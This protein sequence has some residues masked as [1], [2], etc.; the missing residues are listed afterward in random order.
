MTDH[1]FDALREIEHAKWLTAAVYETTYSEN[2]FSG[3]PY[4]AFLAASFATD[5]MTQLEQD[6]LNAV[7]ELIRLHDITA[8]L[9]HI[10]TET[11]GRAAEALDAVYTEAMQPQLLR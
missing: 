8:E 11:L 5:I 2:L 6:K 10:L 7:L 9:L 4:S 1:I 3:T